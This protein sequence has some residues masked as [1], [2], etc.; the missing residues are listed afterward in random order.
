MAMRRA[1]T[2][3]VDTRWCRGYMIASHRIQPRGSVM[4][5][6]EAERDGKPTAVDDVL[7]RHD[8]KTSDAVNV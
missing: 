1:D 6:F 2:S 7:T 8:V 5:R 4:Y 3:D